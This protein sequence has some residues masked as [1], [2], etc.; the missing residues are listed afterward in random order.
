M[1]NR[2]LLT[3]AR[4]RPDARAVRGRG[5]PR[6]RLLPRLRA[7]PQGQCQR[8]RRWVR[9]RPDP[10]AA[11]PS[12]SS[13]TYSSC[14]KSSARTRLCALCALGSRR[15]CKR[16]MARLC[17]RWI[18]KPFSLTLPRTGCQLRG[19]MWPIRPSSPCP[20][21]CRIC[22][23]DSTSSPNGGSMASPLSSTSRR[24]STRTHF[25]LLLCTAPRR[26]ETG[27][28]TPC[29][30]TM[31]FTGPCA[32]HPSHAASPSAAEILEP[33][34]PK[35]EDNPCPWRQGRLRVHSSR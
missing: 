3:K 2:A 19:R 14:R 35:S 24:S 27:P 9:P 23:T 7:K 20:R 34:L 4:A 22:T 8:R 21:G 17:S 18:P 15:S 11:L 26:L 33:P 13:S 30:S 1:V 12:H 31:S 5:R 6:E 28:W 16:S 25:S 29:P 10:R 32:S